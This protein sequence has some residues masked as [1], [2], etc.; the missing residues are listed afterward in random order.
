MHDNVRPTFA[1]QRNLIRFRLKIDIGIDLWI[2]FDA[3]FGH[4]RNRDQALIEIMATSD[5]RSMS[6]THQTG[7][8]GCD[9][10]ASALIKLAR[11]S[12]DQGNSGS[13]SCLIHL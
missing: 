8:S 3:S 2:G 7:H 5:R 6:P 13:R 11:R 1:L 10:H 4:T 9:H 12:G